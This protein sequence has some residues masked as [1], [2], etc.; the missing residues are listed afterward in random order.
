MQ[1]TLYCRISRDLFLDPLW[2][3]VM[4]RDRLSSLLHD[5]Q[6][7]FRQTKLRV[8]NSPI[9]LTEFY[10]LNFEIILGSNLTKYDF[11]NGSNRI[12]L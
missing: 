9:W 3:H 4:L 6:F 11:L 12:Q 2:S 1:K 10:S 7:Y 8:P 5:F